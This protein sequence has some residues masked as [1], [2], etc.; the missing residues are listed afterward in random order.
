M[1]KLPYIDKLNIKY[2]FN[3]I[4]LDNML[5]FNN[6][7][8]LNTLLEIYLDKYKNKDVAKDGFNELLFKIFPFFIISN[9]KKKEEIGKEI[10]YNILNSISNKSISGI[11][12]EATGRLSRRFTAAKSIFK[13]KYKGSLKNIHSSYKGLSSV[14]LRGHAKSN[15]QYTNINSKTR[16]GSFGIKG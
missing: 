8:N 16:N 13:F 14:I 4:K 10:E 9:M 1:V 3:K 11:R 5:L 7:Q 12:L 15:I 2:D 6:I